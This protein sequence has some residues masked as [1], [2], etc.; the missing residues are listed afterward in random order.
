M[1]LFLHRAGLSQPDAAPPAAFS[2]SMTA[3]NF[4][5]AV[6]GY[7]NG[8]GIPA[9]GS[10]DQQ[11]IPGETLNLLAGPPL[12]GIQFAGDVTSSVAGLSVWVDGVEYPFDSQDWT[13]V[14]PANVTTGSWTSGAPTFA[15]AVTYFIEIK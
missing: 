11:P 4:S 3:G 13:H 8:T 6:F 12:S 15:N 9:F 10:I 7:S 5:G 14:M 2:C 1:S